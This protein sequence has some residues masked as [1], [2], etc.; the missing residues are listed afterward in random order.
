MFCKKALR[1]IYF[2]ICMLHY[3]I[4]IVYYSFNYFC[5]LKHSCP[6][7]RRVIAVSCCSIAFRLHYRDT[8]NIRDITMCGLHSF[9]L[10]NNSVQKP[11]PSS[12]SASVNFLQQQLKILS[13]SRCCIASWAKLN[14]VFTREISRELLTTETCGHIIHHIIIIAATFSFSRVLPKIKSNHIKLYVT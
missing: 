8:E 12:S 11:K 1:K 9:W 10:T 6:Q 5:I 2:N 4:A 14:P 13:L 3:I 7:G